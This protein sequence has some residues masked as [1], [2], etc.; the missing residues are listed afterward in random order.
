MSGKWREGL[1]PRS[2]IEE[3]VKM[4]LGPYRYQP[5]VMAQATQTLIKMLNEQR[6]LTIKEG[7]M[8]AEDRRDEAL[9]VGEGQDGYIRP[10]RLRRPLNETE[11]ALMGKGPD[12]K[13]R[14]AQAVFGKKMADD[15]EKDK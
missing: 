1:L 8:R 6:E 12:W 4:F 13:Q 2:R 11:K 9:G 14:L 10:R 15:E 7:R 5:N 3:Y